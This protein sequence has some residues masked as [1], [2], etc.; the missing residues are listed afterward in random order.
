[1]KLLRGGAVVHL[2]GYCLSYILYH[3]FL[4][5]VD[6]DSDSAGYERSAHIT[7]ANVLQVQDITKISK[8]TIP[9]LLSLYFVGPRCTLAALFFSIH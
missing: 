8:K 1:M 6:V 4:S 3:I 7:L 2:D 5:E 9:T